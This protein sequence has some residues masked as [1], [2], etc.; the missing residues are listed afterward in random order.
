[1]NSVRR[2]LI[3]D[4]RIADCRA[5]DPLDISI[6]FRRG[7]FRLPISDFRFPIRRLSRARSIGEFGA[8]PIPM[9][10]VQPGRFPFDFGFDFDCDFNS[11]K[12]SDSDFKIYVCLI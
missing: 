2:F 12:N 3:P 8:V 6:E 9:S 4:F 11:K 5:R 1:M 10:V 7:D